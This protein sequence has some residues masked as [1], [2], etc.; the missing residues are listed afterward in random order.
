MEKMKPV[1][2]MTKETVT[3]EMLSLVLFIAHQGVVS[4]PVKFMY[5]LLLQLLAQF[6]L[7]PQI[8]PFDILCW[9]GCAGWMGLIAAVHAS[10]Q[11]LVPT[12][13]EERFPCN[14]GSR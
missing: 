5:M 7:C 6:L 9:A 10:S 14:E 8:S 4:M 12:G 3:F 13:A 2:L 1:T 11:G